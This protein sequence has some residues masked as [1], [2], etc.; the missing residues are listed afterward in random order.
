M[1]IAGGGN[2]E[3]SSTEADRLQREAERIRQQ[4]REMEAALE[5]ERTTS[6]D[7]RAPPPKTE[8][9]EQTGSRTLRGK[10]VLVAGANGRLGS[11]VCRY[12]LR[13]NPETEVVAAV[14]VVGENSSRGYGR[15]SYEVGA[16][17]GIGQLGPI[18]SSEDDGRTASFQWHEGM[19]GYNLQ[20]LRVVECELLDPVQCS[21]VVEGCDA[22]I[23]C[24]S[25]FN[26]NQPRALSGLNVAFLFRA[27]TI[28]DKGR[29]E[30][31][32]LQNMLG[33]LKRERQEKLSRSR[34]G[35]ATV[36]TANDPINF[37]LVSTAPEALDDFETP[38]GS[39][40]G[41]KRQGEKMM[42]NDFPSLDSV[43]L[44]MGR[45][46]DNFVQED[47]DIIFT[48]DSGNGDQSSMAKRRR[49]INRR[50]AARAAVDALTNNE[51]VGKVVQTWTVEK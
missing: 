46:E 9:E 41:L 2:E 40:L 47:L 7:L 21:S 24:A 10:R 29:V 22:I 44:Q 5:S 16:E 25:D 18:W 31:E 19:S 33:A 13:N 30:I 50:D 48:T 51:L 45:Y 23:W 6:R 35:G 36:G 38:F 4:I 11:M 12:L 26:G 1:L 15:L 32:G 28:P 20:N 39:F 14:H 42:L 43:V 17:D 8:A 37:V 3:A 34:L 49:L 27:I